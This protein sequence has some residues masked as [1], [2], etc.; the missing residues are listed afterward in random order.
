[1]RGVWFLFPK[2]CSMHWCRGVLVGGHVT[3][4]DEHE[5]LPRAVTDEAD[6][7][8][9]AKQSAYTG[10]SKGRLWWWKRERAS[11]ARSFGCRC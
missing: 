6:I 2:C 5:P 10:S 8:C 7:A 11:D 1:M 4:D 3:P 9:L